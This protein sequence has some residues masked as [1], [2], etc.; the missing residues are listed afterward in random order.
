MYKKVKQKPLYNKAVLQPVPE[1]LA[2][3]IGL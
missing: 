1:A 3:Q 2:E